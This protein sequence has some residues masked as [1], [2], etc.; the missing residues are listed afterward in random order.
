MKI[1]DRTKDVIKSGGEFISGPQLE[2]EAMAHPAVEEAA[3][4]GVADEKWGERPLLFVDVASAER[5]ARLTED[6][7]RGFLKGRVAR[8]WVPDRV[9]VGVGNIPHGATGKVDKKELRR[10]YL[11]TESAVPPAQQE[12]QK[13][14]SKL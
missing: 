7:V 6:E 11:G 2:A 3:A 10:R 4:I 9:I 8:W 5:A 12:Q 14:L 1:V 13:P